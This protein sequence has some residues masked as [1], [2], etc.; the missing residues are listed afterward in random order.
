[1]P[2]IH[3]TAIVDPQ[4]QIGSNVTIGPFSIVEG[5]TVIGNGSQL[6]GHAVIKA[7]TE[8]GKDNKVYE[9]AVLGGRPQH[10]QAG[11]RVGRLK[12]GDGNIIRENATINCG[13]QEHSCT[14]VGN[15]NMFMVNA[16]VGHDC[17]VGEHTI[18]TNN[19]M[20]AGHVTIE[21]RAYISGA[22]GIHQFCRVGQLAMVGGQAHISQD[23]LPFVMI[24][25]LSSEVVGLNRIGLRRSGYAREDILQLKKAYRVIYRSELTFGEILQ[26]LQQQFPTGPAAAFFEFML[27]GKRG[28]VRERRAPPKSTIKLFPSDDREGS[29]DEAEAVRNAG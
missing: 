11:E 1:M 28:F 15:G 3:A 16:H 26:T 10:V 9:G 25:G 27:A 20:I 21:S 17:H 13:L 18:V 22:A 19:A 12:I 7:R 4:A 23:V 24:D 29:D 2:N 5:D 6:A 8:L 14:V